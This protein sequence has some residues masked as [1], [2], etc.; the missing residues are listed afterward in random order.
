MWR[1][2]IDIFRN[3]FEFRIR[4]A[5]SI[6]IGILFGL[7]FLRLN[8]D[9]QS[10]QN[11]SAVI[12]MLIINNTFSNV[13]ANADVSCS[14]V[15]ILKA[16]TSSR[17]VVQSTVAVVLQ[18][19]RRRYLSHDTVLRIESSNRTTYVRG[20]NVHHGNDCLL[21]DESLQ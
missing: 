19:T 8:Y 5:L 2:S 21:D 7:L 14:S 4:F 17:V 10:F 20:H 9:Q 1:S 3:P 6:I 15:A 11:I 18:R 13:Q 12:L 16:S